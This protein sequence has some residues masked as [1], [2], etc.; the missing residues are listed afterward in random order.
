MTKIPVLATPTI[1]LASG[2]SQTLHLTGNSVRCFDATGAF[3]LRLD[4]APEIGFARG[5]EVKLPNEFTKIQVIN[6]H[7]GANE[8]KL[9]VA[10]G[11]F[12]ENTFELTQISQSEVVSPS[13]VAFFGSTASTNYTLVFAPRTE[14]KEFIITNTSASDL[15]KL[16]ANPD[17]GSKYALQAGDSITLTTSAN[18][19]VG[20]DSGSCSFEAMEIW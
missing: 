5:R 14:R 6:D 1:T 10:I 20:V 7:N 4:G 18:I 19:Y 13:N 17:G 8:I 11:E 2:A 12:A 3:K 16:R 9:G 15:L